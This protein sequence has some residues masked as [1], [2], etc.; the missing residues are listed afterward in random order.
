MMPATA[1]VLLLRRDHLA[2]SK[3]PQVGVWSSQ[4]DAAPRVSRTTQTY[5][6][7]LVSVKRFHLVLLDHRQ[8]TH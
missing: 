7:R 5:L 2:L 8:G 3:V 1:C 6:N 4:V